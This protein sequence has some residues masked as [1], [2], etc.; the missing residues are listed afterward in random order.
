[1]LWMNSAGLA[2]AQGFMRWQQRYWD[3]IALQ[4][5]R[6]SHAAACAALPSAEAAAATGAGHAGRAPF[7][8]S[9]NS[10]FKLFEEGPG[11]GGPQVDVEGAVG[12]DGA[13]QRR[14]GAHQH[15][16]AD[17]PDPDAK[18]HFLRALLD[19]EGQEHLEDL[20]E[21]IL[22]G[23]VWTR[24]CRM[25]HSL[26]DPWVGQHPETAMSTATSLEPS[27]AMNAMP[28]E[29]TRSASTGQAFA[30]IGGGHAGAAGG[31]GTWAAAAGGSAGS[32][33]AHGDAS[34]QGT[35]SIIAPMPEG[36][37]RG[38]GANPQGT[39]SAPSKHT[40]RFFSLAQSTS[41]GQAMPGSAELP[42]PKP[43]SDSACL[44]T[45]G[46][47]M[48]GFSTCTL[49]GAGAGA[50]GGDSHPKSL[51]LPPP[52]P[53][54]MGSGAERGSVPTF[55]QRGT[56]GSSSYQSTPDTSAAHLRGVRRR[57]S[58]SWLLQVGVWDSV[59]AVELTDPLPWQLLA[60]CSCCC[61]CDD[62]W[63]HAHALLGSR[64]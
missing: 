28:S 7:V 3:S 49:Y 30:G 10:A 54:R 9:S 45:L 34:S 24:V 31:V 13:S 48:D 55:L 15:M 43:R 63:L 47:M 25:R 22:S 23:S 1:M 59:V 37:G 57:A 46:A 41:L 26:P 44:Q 17:G 50:H 35:A 52:I 14:A 27:L 62:C 21:T 8:S 4:A 38:D 2:F 18:P 36:R 58:S 51:Q 39:A 64:A 11:G 33:G 5:K 12:T 40:A 29:S 32:A 60:A 20:L 56:V 16:Q 42:Q 53:T 6:P 19:L 61:S